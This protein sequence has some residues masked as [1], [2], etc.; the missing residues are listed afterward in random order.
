MQR[1][2]SACSLACRQAERG[3]GE[4]KVRRR[5]RVANEVWVKIV[6]DYRKESSSPALER[7]RKVVGERER[8]R[9]YTV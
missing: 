5:E 8:E 1:L 6:G 9:N 7:E 3:R 2:S 4:Q